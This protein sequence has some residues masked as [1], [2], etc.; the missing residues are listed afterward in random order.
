VF[1]MQVVMRELSSVYGE[2]VGAAGS[3]SM[4]T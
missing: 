3:E 4:P 2:L 1:S